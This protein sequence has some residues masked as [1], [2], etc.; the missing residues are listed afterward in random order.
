MN[1]ESRA[2]SRRPASAR[3]DP[4]R[5]RSERA[6]KKLNAASNRSGS[7]ERPEGPRRGRGP[8]RLP[9]R[10]LA[11][12]EQLDATQPLGSYAGAM[13]LGQFMPSSYLEYAVDLDG[14]GR[15]DLWDSL[16]DVIGSVANYLHRHGWQPG[17][18]VT[19]RAGVA[20]D[21]D[22]DLVSRSNL[23]PGKTVAELAESGFVPVDPVPSNTP[24]AVTRLREETGDSYWLTFQNFYVITRYNRS[25]LY[26]MA[27]YQLSEE[28]MR[29]MDS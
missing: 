7:T 18:P 26:A 1:A 9:A 13:G 23:K 22:M 14:D 21:A 6:K 3:A 15:R 20:E 19:T 4:A 28:L 2:T 16:A 29:G 10:L 24:G 27:V 11:R 12:E 5:S 25:P 17:Q 8:V